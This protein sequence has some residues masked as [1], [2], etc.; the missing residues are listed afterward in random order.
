MMTVWI[1]SAKYQYISLKLLL[2]GKQWTQFSSLSLWQIHN[3]TH[4][5][6]SHKLLLKWKFKIQSIISFKDKFW[7]YC[8]LVP[9]D[10]YVVILP[11]FILYC[12]V[13]PRE[14]WEAR[15]SGTLKNMHK[16]NTSKRLLVTFSNNS[17][18]HEVQSQ[19]TISLTLSFA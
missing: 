16:K 14:R 2:T 9:S 5:N 7:V 12:F 4:N 11:D 3:Y 10:K 15:Q 8:Y 6:Y 17:H 13:M 18:M 1:F 19:T